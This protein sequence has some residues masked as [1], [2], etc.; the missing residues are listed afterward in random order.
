MKKVIYY[1]TGTGNSLRAAQK[2]AEAMHDTDL[3]SMRCI[4]EEVSAKDADVIGFTFPIYH[5]M[6][7][8]PISAF[9]KA[10]EIN[11]KAYCFAVSTP[12]VVNGLSFEMLDEILKAKGACLS[13][14]NILYSVANL[15]LVYS[16]KPFPRIRIPRA[17]KSLAKIADEIANKK[18]INYPRANL[19][20]RKIYPKM[21]PKYLPVQHETDRGFIIKVSCIGCATCESVCPQ[22]NIIMKN[23]RP[24]FL[25]HC[26]SCM[27]CIAYCPKEAIGYIL[28]QELKNQFPH[29]P[30]V[31]CM[32]L[33]DNRK[34][35]HNPYITAND[36]AKTKSHVD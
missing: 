32:K 28:P 5:W 25:H 16:P 12:G 2:I 19:L 7:A 8:E 29:D 27:A 20:T 26:C 11:P 31:M 21:M 9:I 22:L 13:Y 15:V 30:F 23:G 17:E 10:L 6:L 4:P 3:I 14:G 24:L 35:Y 34:R 18:E 33:P 1:F 36:I